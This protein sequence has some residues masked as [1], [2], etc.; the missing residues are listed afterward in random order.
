MT[1]AS[2]S[3][4]S[5]EIAVKRSGAAS[6]RPEVNAA[7]TSVSVRSPTTS[8]AGVVGVVGA[9]ASTPPAAS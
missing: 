5:A 9:C 3:D 8:S 4:P 2:T 6:S 1:Q 7:P